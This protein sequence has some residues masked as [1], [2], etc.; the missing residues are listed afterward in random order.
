MILL[1]VYC[2]VYFAVYEQFMQQKSAIGTR[3]TFTRIFYIQNL[4]LDYE[5][6]SDME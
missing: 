2:N 4:A 6:T 1:G 3:K 5:R